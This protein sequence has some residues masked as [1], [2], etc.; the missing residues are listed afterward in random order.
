MDSTAKFYMETATTEITLYRATRPLQSVSHLET[1]TVVHGWFRSL[2]HVPSAKT[3]R[4]KPST[5]KDTALL[6]FHPLVS[7]P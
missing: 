2:R 6:G 3:H 4:L 7:T 1:L 5:Q